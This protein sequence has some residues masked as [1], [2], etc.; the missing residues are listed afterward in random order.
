MDGILQRVPFVKAKEEDEDVSKVRTI[1]PKVRS[2]EAEGKEAKEFYESLIGKTGQSDEFIDN[3]ASKS[4]SGTKLGTQSAVR[5]RST[6][7]EFGFMKTLASP[8]SSPETSAQTRRKRSTSGRSRKG[9]SSA[10]TS[11]TNG[12]A[13]SYISEAYSVRTRAEVDLN[14]RLCKGASNFL[15]CAQ[16]G[17]LNTLKLHLERGV[18]INVQDVYSWTA[19]MCAAYAGHSEVLQFLL[20]S[21]AN[22]YLVDNQGQNVLTIAE[23]VK[24]KNK[25]ICKMIRDFM[26]GKSDWRAIKKE[27]SPKYDKFYCDNC[28]M[29]FGDITRQRHETSTIHLF[30]SKPKGDRSTFYHLPENNKGF[31]LLVQSGWDKEKGLGPEGKG[32]KFP[33]KTV[34]KR[35]RLGLGNPNK[36]SAKVTH[37]APHDT[38]AVKRPRLDD[39]SK[40][41][42][43]MRKSTL[44]KREQ[45][46]VLSKEK[47]KEMDFRIA[48]NTDF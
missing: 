29:E 18:D 3:G 7:D 46:K 30:N 33:V 45:A 11:S 1:K 44:S 28:K 10:P 40:N 38:D 24:P 31:K 6:S 23:S 41:E 12:I 4:G 17:D 13:H 25:T 16:E 5:K 32:N 42:R 34:L 47:Q 15:K 39:E 22:V 35:D 21:G 8:C 2:S 37:F 26:D 43:K 19:A 48:F 14:A 9:K 36:A 20:E 27:E